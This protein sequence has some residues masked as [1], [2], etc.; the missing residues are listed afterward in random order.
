MERGGSE[1]DRGRSTTIDRS[2]ETILVV[3]DDSSIRDALTELLETE[4]YAV[5]A[6]ANG[7]A[8]L[9]R[10][11]AGLRPR[12]I[13]LDLMMPVMDGWDFR[14]EQ[15]R[16]PDL[17][18]IPVIIITAAGFSVETMRA[19]LGDIELVPKPLPTEQLLTA[20]KRFA[21]SGAHA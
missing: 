7:Y 8:A 21:P 15:L 16:D 6:A 12:M 2:D 20:V 18:D 1:L 10:L 17:R 13:F 5:A 4:G 9:R 11:R 14:T 19:Q 3:D